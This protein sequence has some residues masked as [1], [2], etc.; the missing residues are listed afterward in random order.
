LH[1]LISSA[2][3][4]V[5]KRQTTS[6][7]QRGIGDV[8]IAWENEAFLSVKEFGTDK[9]E[10]VV[11]SVSILAEPPVAVVDKVVDKKGTRKLAEAYL[12]Y[13]YS[14]QGQ[15]IAARNYYRPRSK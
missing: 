8:L 2:A 12:N 9:F 14:P 1:L 10:I 7:V 5:Y 6:F 11:P 13:L 4:D 15:E 3:S